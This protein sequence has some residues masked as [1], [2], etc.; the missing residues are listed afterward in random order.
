[1]GLHLKLVS[2]LR[3]VF[4]QLDSKPKSKRVDEKRLGSQ[5][6]TR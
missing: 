4:S 3:D 2:V 5:F 1:V 6:F